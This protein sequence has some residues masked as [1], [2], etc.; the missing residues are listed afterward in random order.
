MQEAITQEISTVV[1][2]VATA[3]AAG[4]TTRGQQQLQQLRQLQ[5]GSPATA[6]PTAASTAT[7]LRPC[8]KPSRGQLQ[9]PLLQRQYQHPSGQQL[10]PSTA[11]LQPTTSLQ[12]GRVQPELHSPT[13]S[14]PPPPAYN[15]A[16]C[17]AATQPLA[18]PTTPPQHRPTLS[19]T[20]TRVNSTTS[21]G[22][23]TIRTRAGGH[24]TRE[25]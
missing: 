7:H 3:T 8:S 5:P 23:R 21:S 24:R 6:S 17:R 20:A 9:H 19:V 2:V 13:T 22:T 12:P 4:V 25:L 16:S 15:Y 14:P 10:Q 11:E 1:E 18:S